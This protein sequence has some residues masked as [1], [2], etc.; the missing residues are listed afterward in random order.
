MSCKGQT[1][2]KAWSFAVRRTICEKGGT[3]KRQ[4][5]SNG[6]AESE[7]E[8]ERER[9]TERDRQTYK[10]NEIKNERMRVNTNRSFSHYKIITIKLDF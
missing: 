10:E 1:G 8:N 9:E 2:R 5:T 3:S 7:R 6:V 4:A